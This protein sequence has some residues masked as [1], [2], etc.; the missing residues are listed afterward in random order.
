MTKKK[1]K[2]KSKLQL[3][4]E[5]IAACKDTRGRIRPE[6]VVEA[7]RNPDSV[8]HDEFEWNIGEAAQK[9]WVSRARELI[10]EV[11][12]VITYEDR[13]VVAPYYVSDPSDDESSYIET[14][15]IA[16]KANLAKQTIVD[17]MARIKAAIHRASSL[18]TIFNMTSTFEQM[19]DLAVT[20]ERQLDD[21]E[22]EERPSA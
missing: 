1:A 18:A 5:A 14:T 15:R 16:R 4:A 3:K 22:V 10:R 9:Y 12:L 19:L 21:D 20:I 8:L 11:K 13:R 2:V 6:A 7:A 17:E